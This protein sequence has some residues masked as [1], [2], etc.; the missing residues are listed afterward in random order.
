MSRARNLAGL[1][2]AAALLAAAAASC[3]HDADDA[4][5]A[6]EAAPVVPVRVAALARVTFHDAVSA[7]GQW[8][9]ANELVLAAPFPAYVESLRVEVGDAVVRGQTVAALVTRESRAAV[10]G[11]QQ[12][13][14]SAADPAA[15]AQAERALAQ[16]RR[17]LVRM[18]LVAPA[19][20]TVVLRS[21]AP[22]SELAEG[23][24]VLAIVSPQD[25][26]FEAHVAARDAARVRAGQSAR[27]VMEDGTA[28]DAT[29]R[30]A[31]PQTSAADQAALVW[32]APAR[33]GVPGWIGRFGTASIAAGG[34]RT[35]IG[36]PDSAIVSDDLT[37][38]MR[39][40]V[41]GAGQVARWRDVTLGLAEG[42]WHEL[43]SPV[44]AAGTLAIVSGQRGLPDSTRVSREP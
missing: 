32:L 29:V 3:G 33:P 19:A 8:R 34:S 35:A 4:R 27:I 21:A 25:F 20:G 1:A 9:S 2:L 23:A 18:P 22:G 12:L 28:L 10:L 14:A 7:P 39:I 43:R 36:V 17:D 13:V 30:R 11:A 24:E 16:A 41:V 15:R 26:V 40:A 6:P 38:T 31:L 37:G 42:G 5:E 44:L